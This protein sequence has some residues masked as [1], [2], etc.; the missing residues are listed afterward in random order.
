MAKNK[1][2]MPSRRRGGATADQP[3]PPL[4][5]AV[6]GKAL[7]IAREN[8][9]LVGLT[10]GSVLLSIVVAFPP[11]TPVLTTAPI[12][13]PLLRRLRAHEY[14]A[15]TGALWRWALTLY[16]TVLVS[17]AFVYHRMLSGFPFSENAVQGVERALDGSG[18]PTAGFVYMLGGIAAFTVLAA[19]SRGIAACVWSSIALGAAAAAS[20]VLFAN[21]NNVILIA[22]IACPPW[23]WALF[24]GALLVFTPAT[25]WGGKRLYGIRSDDADYTHSK[26]RWMIPA[27]L[28]LLAL[29]LRLVLAGPYVSLAQ[30]WTVH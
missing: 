20:S 10:I 4:E 12:V 2:H 22:L 6:D 7:R 25:V 11:L 16:L 19:A 23:Q 1:R 3:T 9:R 17:A 29:L 28:V 13:R 8:G 26:R 15:V 18:G 27:G 5:V 24:A 30:H 21:G 14:A